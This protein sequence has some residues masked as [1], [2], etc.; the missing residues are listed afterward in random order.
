VGGDTITGNF[1]QLVPNG[2]TGWTG[3]STTSDAN[4]HYDYDVEIT[5]VGGVINPP[6]DKRN[7]FGW[8]QKEC[9]LGLQLYSDERHDDPLDHVGVFSR[10]GLW[11]QSWILSK[12]QNIQPVELDF[13]EVDAKLSNYLRP[14]GGANYADNIW[15]NFSSSCLTDRCFP[16]DSHDTP[17]TAIPSLQNTCFSDEFNHIKPTDSEIIHT[18]ITYY[19]ILR[20]IGSQYSAPDGI[21]DSSSDHTDDSFYFAFPYKH[22]LCT[23]ANKVESFEVPISYCFTTKYTMSNSDNYVYYPPDKL[24]Y[25]NNPT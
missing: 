17:D 8:Y 9:Y 19:Q 14:G 16:H 25:K 10:M 3:D 1:L 18:D 4:F 21:Y 5:Q 12:V 11:M 22:I 6:F 7:Y 23:K 2:V 13:G 20:G 15:N 24:T